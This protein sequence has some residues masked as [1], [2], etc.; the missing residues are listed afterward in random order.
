MNKGKDQLEE[1]DKEVGKVS[2]M[3]TSPIDKS[4]VIFLGTH[5]LNWISENCG[6]AIAALNHGRKI[7]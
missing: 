2:E 3:I 4:L 1:D 6:Q 7:Q 5:G